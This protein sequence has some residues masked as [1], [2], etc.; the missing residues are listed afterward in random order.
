MSAPSLFDAAAERLALES[1]IP[2][3]QAKLRVAGTD[4]PP[5]G[6]LLN[7]NYG[8]RPGKAHNLKDCQRC[9]ACGGIIADNLTMCFP[10]RGRANASK[11][12]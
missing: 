10:C 8:L 1:G 4:A 6:P 3:S 11:R 9:V 5:S 7:S 12:T 2:R